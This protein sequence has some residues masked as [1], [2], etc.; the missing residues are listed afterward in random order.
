MIEGAST[1]SLD[2]TIAFAFACL[3]GGCGSSTPKPVSPSVATTM[4]V[5]V[6]TTAATNAGDPLYG[7]VRTLDAKAAPAAEAYQDISSRLFA[8]PPDPTVI[9]SEPIIPG[10]ATTFE[11]DTSASKG[12]VVYFLFTNPGA[13]WRVPLRPPFPKVLTIELDANQVKTVQ[14]K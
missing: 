7:M 10:A 2:R 11:V 1:W 14:K 9:A 5:V 6:Q 3:L 4:Q 13:N 12:L 8:S